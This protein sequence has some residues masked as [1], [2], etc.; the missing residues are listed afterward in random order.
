M[1]IPL[2]GPIRSAFSSSVASGRPTSR[3]MRSMRLF[4]P[5]P[6]PKT[7]GELIGMALSDRQAQMGHSDVRMTLHYTHSD[8]YRR[9]QS[10]KEL[11]ARLI[12]SVNCPEIN[13]VLTPNDNTTRVM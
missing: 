6:P 7:R 12:G 8:L 11:T 3:S 4:S 13:P 10:I 2:A 1:G 5:K 9:R